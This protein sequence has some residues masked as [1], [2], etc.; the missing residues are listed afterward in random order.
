MRVCV[1]LYIY[2][3]TYLFMY[4]CN[5][6]YLQCICHGLGAPRPWNSSQPGNLNQGRE[7]SETAACLVRSIR[8]NTLH[9]VLG[10]QLAK[11]EQIP[12]KQTGSSVNVMSH[13]STSRVP[14]NIQG[15]VRGCVVTTWEVQLLLQV[16]ALALKKTSFPW[17]YGESKSRGL[18]AR[19]RRLSTA[20]PAALLVQSILL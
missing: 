10:K 16:R 18:F 1:C 15:H 11:T 17:R 7:S 8:S 20:H 5:C 2:I 14:R 19:R 12:W 4:I 3:F 6:T 9:Q 13:A